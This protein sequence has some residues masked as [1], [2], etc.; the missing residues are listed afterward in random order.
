MNRQNNNK[1]TPLKLPWPDPSLKLDIYKTTFCC[2]DDCIVHGDSSLFNRLSSCCYYREQ[3][4]RRRPV[5]LGANGMFSYSEK[6]Y[7]TTN[8]KVTSCRNDYEFH[9]H[10]LNFKKLPCSRGACAEKYCPFYHD[11]AE[12]DAYIEFRLFLDNAAYKIGL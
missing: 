7:F 5:E 2:A 12:R 4:E 3:S 1:E 9:Y 11:V 8:E 6:Y 10:P